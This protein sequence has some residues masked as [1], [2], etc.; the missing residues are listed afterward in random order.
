MW[1]SLSRPVAGRTSS[2]WDG[3]IASAAVFACLNVG[4]TGWDGA[5][6]PIFLPCPALSLYISAA[7]V[8]TAPLRRPARLLLLMCRA[9]VSPQPSWWSHSPSPPSTVPARR[10]GCGHVDAV[11]GGVAD[12]GL[13]SPTV[14]YRER[15]ARIASKPAAV[16]HSH[17]MLVS[18]NGPIRCG[19]VSHPRR[20]YQ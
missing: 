5:P 7:T 8:P 4:D 12:A 17:R 20:Q 11:C 6:D 16:P 3:G 2:D 13:H 19:G 15:K 14:S 10:F 9:V 1:W 18:I